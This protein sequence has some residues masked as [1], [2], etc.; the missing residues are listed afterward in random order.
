MFKWTCLL[1]AVV[2]L[3]GFG[4]MLNDMR[5]E[6]KRLAPQVEELTDRTEALVDRL[7]TQLPQVLSHAERVSTQLDSHLPRILSQTESAS[8]TI[9]TQLPRLLKN[10]EALLVHSEVAVDNLAEVSDS[11]KQYKGLMGVV[12]AA[13]QSKG[14]FSYGTGLLGFLGRSNATIGVKKP[15]SGQALQNAMPAR[16]WAS[17]AQGDV[18][19]LSLIGKTKEDMLHGL[20]RTRSVNP[21]HIQVGDQPPRL[22]ADWLKE[23]HPDSKGLK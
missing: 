5:L 16:Q 7:D 19:F 23:S 15:G 12:H 20:A 21:L 8:K 22:L 18:H 3:A 14:L 1:V 4:W 11:F 13:T 2:A 9:N 17:A 6:V 10:S